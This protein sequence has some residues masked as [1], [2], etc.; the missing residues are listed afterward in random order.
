MVLTR[1]QSKAISRWLPNEII[2]EIIQA[3]PCRTDRAALCATS[4]L[5]YG[6]SIPVLYREVDLDS[7]SCARSFS[8]SIVSNPTL[9]GSVRSLTFIKGEG[10][11]WDS[12]R[13]IDVSERLLH[14]LK[15]LLKLEYL[16]IDLYLLD[17]EHLCT[18][19]DC[20]FPYLIDLR[21]LEVLEAKHLAPATSFLL[22]H[23]QLISLSMPP[24]EADELPCQIPLWTLK[25]M[26]RDGV[27]FICSNEYFGD[28]ATA[29]LDALSKHMP[30]MKTLQLRVL[31]L[32]SDLRRALF[33]DIERRLPHFQGLRFLFIED[34]DRATL[35]AFGAACSTLE[36]YDN[37][38]RKDDGTW[39]E[40]PTDSKAL[41]GLGGVHFF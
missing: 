32:D 19:L 41:F 34:T 25:S 4:K 28:R 35:E 9:S 29:I 27:P 12:R 40:Y 6:I 7:Y 33:T 38:W 20:T 39:Q 17:E 8:A 1:R 16:S 5:F 10:P 36:V 15:S 2:S 18:L 24:P 31:E 30:R 14:S 26:A 13:P 23:P 3:T 11:A 21:L 37:L 22:R